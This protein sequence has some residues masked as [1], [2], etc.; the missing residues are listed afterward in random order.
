M[1]AN[2]ALEMLTDYYTTPSAYDPDSE[3]ITIGQ[4]LNDA[5]RSRGFDAIRANI[6]SSYGPSYVQSRGPEFGEVAIL[7]PA[8]QVMYPGNPALESFL[9]MLRESQ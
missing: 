6:P 9:Q 5:A 1:T 8:E 2:R 3:I 7:N 4:A